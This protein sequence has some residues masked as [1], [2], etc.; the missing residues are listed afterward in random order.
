MINV[1]LLLVYPRNYLRYLHDVF[2]FFV[3]VVLQDV[4][5]M[6]PDEDVKK[7]L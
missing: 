5:Q 4:H 6:P 1:D 7:K 2:F 3:V